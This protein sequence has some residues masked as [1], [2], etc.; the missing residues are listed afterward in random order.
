MPVRNKQI[1]LST[2]IFPNLTATQTVGIGRC[3]VICCRGKTLR[4]SCLNPYRHIGGN[5]ENECHRDGPAG[6]AHDESRHHGHLIAS[7]SGLL[8]LLEI[9]HGIE[10]LGESASTK[11]GMPAG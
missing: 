7:D 4:V 2:T 3:G 5:G 8:M 11:R 6:D 1:S 9:L 10:P